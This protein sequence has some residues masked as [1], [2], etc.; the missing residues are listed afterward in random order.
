MVFSLF[1]SYPNGQYLGQLVLNTS[2]D[3]ELITARSSHHHLTVLIANKNSQMLIA[4]HVPGNL[5]EHGVKV[6]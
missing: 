6:L 5:L 3:K 2:G 1:D 4:F